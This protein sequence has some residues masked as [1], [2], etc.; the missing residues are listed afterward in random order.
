MWKEDTPEDIDI[1]VSNDING[2]FDATLFM[3]DPMDVLNAIEIIKNNFKMLQIVFM[4][5]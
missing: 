4:E 1:I 5:M 2:D 3:K